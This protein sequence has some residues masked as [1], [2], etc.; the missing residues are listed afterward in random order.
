MLNHP[1][2]CVQNVKDQAEY[3]PNE[4]RLSAAGAPFAPY[5]AQTKV[6]T[7]YQQGRESTAT[8][9][10][11][12][13]TDY[14]TADDVSNRTI[15]NDIDYDRIIADAGDNVTQAERDALHHAEESLW[16]ERTSS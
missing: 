11:V 9:A 7:L 1:L 13:V 16:Q 2:I 6:V 15:W 4:I 14:D 3:K 10:G 12:Q 8:S 5:W